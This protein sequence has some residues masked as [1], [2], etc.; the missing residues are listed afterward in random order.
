M[1]TPRH[2]IE[3]DIPD[4]VMP[5]LYEHAKMKCLSYN[6]KV[7]KREDYTDEQL[8]E[9]NLMG[10]IGT[11][12][13]VWVQTGSNLLY[14]RHMEE[15]G[16]RLEGDGGTDIP[17]ARVDCKCS[18]RRTDLRL[19]RHRL[20]VRPDELHEDT[21]YVLVICDEYSEDGAEGWLMGWMYDWEILENYHHHGKFGDAYCVYA[22]L[23]HPMPNP[24]WGDME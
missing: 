24:R 16:D 17:G 13:G 7:R 4:M 1:L 8:F 9:D 20:A 3:F 6:S 15:T 14:Y 2:L 5:S 10:A 11:Y 19:G 18:Y 21:V 22:E 12:V 23:L